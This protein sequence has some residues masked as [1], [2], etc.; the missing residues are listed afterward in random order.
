MAMTHFDSIELNKRERPLKFGSFQIDTVYNQSTVHLV[1]PF[2][3]KTVRKMT[4][5]HFGD[6]ERKAFIIYMVIY[7]VCYN[8]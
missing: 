6:D 2:D 4:E 5:R 3:M 7:S 1:D 8:Q